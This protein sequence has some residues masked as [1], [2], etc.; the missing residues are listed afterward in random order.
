VL[1]KIRHYVPYQGFIWEADVYEGV[2]DGMILAEVELEN[3]DIEVP[4][5]RW[6]GREVTGDHEYKKINMQNKALE[7]NAGL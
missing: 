6:I 4:L 5:P 7:R 1:E 3:A 2:L